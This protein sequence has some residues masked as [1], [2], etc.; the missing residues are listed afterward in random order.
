M[1]DGNWS[2]VG[3]YVAEANCTNKVFHSTRLERCT[4]M[5]VGVLAAALK[6]TPCLVGERYMYKHV[7]RCG[8]GGWE[9]ERKA[10][11]PRNGKPAL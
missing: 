1:G 8:V 9:G 7:L 10:Q 11:W 4:G 3:M 5:G 6:D 2:S